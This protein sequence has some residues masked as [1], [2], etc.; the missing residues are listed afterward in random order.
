M[1]QHQS[2]LHGMRMS[3]RCHHDITWGSALLM[4]AVG[5]A[6]I[7]VDQVSVDRWLVN[8]VSGVRESVGP[9]GQSLTRDLQVGPVCQG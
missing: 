2:V 9:I 1:W 3:A 4:S 6:D 5:P 8:R 7:S